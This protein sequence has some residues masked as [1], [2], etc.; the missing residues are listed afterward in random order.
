MSDTT[1]KNLQLAEDKTAANLPAANLFMHQADG[2]RMADNIMHFARVLRKAGL[3]VGPGKTL[4]AIEAICAVGLGTRE[5]FYWTLHAVF[6]HRRDQREIFDQAF[7][8][9]WRNP[10]FLEKMMQMM[11]PSF[12]TD[13]MVQENLRDNMSPRV[14]EA[15]KGEKPPPILPDLDDMGEEVQLDASMTFSR[16]EVLSTKDFEKMTNAELAEAKQVMSQLTLPIGEVMTR[17]YKRSHLNKKVDMRSTLR[18][19][20][21]RGGDMIWLRHKT[22]RTL[23]PPLV[24]LCDISG[25]MEKY[26]RMFLHF[27]HS[28]T[29]DRDRVHSFLFGTQLNNITRHLRYKD[30][31]E[32]IAKI[33][34]NVKDW[35]GGTRI[36][37][38]LHEFNK[39]WGR[40]VLGQGAWVLLITDG[41]DR[42]GAEGVETEIERLHKS[43]RRLVWLNPLLRY[44]EYAPKT[45]GAQALIKHVD[46]FRPI[47]N[48]ESLSQLAK[49]LADDHVMDHKA[50]VQWRQ[51][52]LSEQD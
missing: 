11:L 18:A 12:K 28:L 1:P 38:S 48:L 41:L 33:G 21:R 31:D 24:V 40:R 15:M 17:R 6:V 46:D 32:A 27:L 2:G 7:H 49:A 34:E 22:P 36:G 20:S 52:A 4:D 51:K 25:S 13:D 5:D 3:P 10:N 16:Q 19:S 47:H 39:F 29:N 23:P 8:V 50:M 35:S 44:N 45:K 43:C 14:A 37:Q 9:F 26:S 42:Q 30:P